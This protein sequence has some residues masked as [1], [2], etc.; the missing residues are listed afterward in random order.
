MSSGARG[1]LKACRA[2]AFVVASVTNTMVVAGELA[3]G[4][5]Y[6]YQ[7]DSNVNRVQDNPISDTIQTGV[8]GLSYQQN[9]E[10]LTANLVAQVSRKLYTK[11]TFAPETAYYANGA[12]VW[13]ISPQLL[14]WRLEDVASQILLDITQPDTPTNRTNSNSLNTGPDLTFR[15]GAD[16]VIL[17]ARYGRFDVQ[18]SG[19]NYR[20]TGFVRYLHPLSSM[21]VVSLNYEP[22]DIYYSPPAVNAQIIR[23]DAY[24]RYQ[25][26]SEVDELTVDLGVTHDAAIGGQDTTKPLIS[27]A[28][29]HRLTPTTAIHT[30]I[31]DRTLDTYSY[32]AS[33]ATTPVPPTDPTAGVGSPSPTVLAGDVYQKR[34]ADLVLVT[35]GTFLGS[36]AQAYAQSIDYQT[37]VDQDYNEWGGRVSATWF[38]SVDLHLRAQAEYIRRTFT[39]STREDADKNANIG[40][41]YLMNPKFSL[42]FLGERL[43][44]STTVAGANYVDL[45]ATMY[46]IYSSNMR[47]YT[48]GYRR[49]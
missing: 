27:I 43:Q 10:A 39:S 24:G 42:A 20:Y 5:A 16:S 9:T 31:L 28:G 25:R 3:Y 19:D 35:R 29:T 13:V 49:N 37:L 14:S 7:Y 2:A 36:T 32:L 34:Y 18:G 11:D 15:L 44:R 46:L 41:L 38:Y 40:F 4:G 22:Q 45:R 8:V 33:G 21:S 1:L 6:S 30:T 47:Q 48:P 26:R 23:E 17:G 12:A